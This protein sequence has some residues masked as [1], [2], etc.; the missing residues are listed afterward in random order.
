MGNVTSLIGVLGNPDNEKN[1]KEALNTKH[2][3]WTIDTCM[4]SDTREYETG[5]KH[6]ELYPCWVIVEQYGTSKE[7]SKK[8][9]A[10]WVKK[11]KSGIK[12]FTDVLQYGL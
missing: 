2:G 1:R 4:V 12:E 10:E 6:P 8:G 11:V 5:I 9:H 7:K 3:K